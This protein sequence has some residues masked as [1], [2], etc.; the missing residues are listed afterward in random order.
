MIK[1]WTDGACSGNPGKGG[2]GL[3]IEDK[4]G[5]KC[6]QQFFDN[7]TN[8]QMELLSI[9]WAIGYANLYQEDVII[10]S[11]SAYAINTLS[12]WKNAW[13]NNGWKKS[14][15]QIPANLN[16]IKAYDILET[17]FKNNITFEKVKGHSNV[18]NNIIADN[19]ATGKI[20]LF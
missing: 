9:L 4:R 3:V 18:K 5:T 15:N 14:D 19:L 17:R 16:I 12:N 6:Y 20:C 10:Y 1:V 2:F 11:D 7:T 8:N 13:K